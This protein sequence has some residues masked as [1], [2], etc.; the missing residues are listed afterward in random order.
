MDK[1]AVPKTTWGELAI[2]EKVYP[3]RLWYMSGDQ[4]S[5]IIDV[6]EQNRKVEIHNYTKDYIARA[7]GVIE[8]PSFEDY[9]AFLESRCFPRTRDKMKLVLEDLGLP[10]YDPFMIIEKTEG[11]MA[12]DDFWIRIER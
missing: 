11:R 1:Y 8:C 9:E 10:F 12:E 4:V 7:F 3:L 2:P 6:D 5:T